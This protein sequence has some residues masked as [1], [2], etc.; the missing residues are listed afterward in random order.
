[1]GNPLP[2]PSRSRKAKTNLNLNRRCTPGSGWQAYTLA[3]NR[4]KTL[5]HALGFIA[6]FQMLL[7][8]GEIGLA[9][10]NIPV[11]SPVDAPVQVVSVPFYTR[12]SYPEALIVAITEPYYVKQGEDKEASNFNLAA[13]AKL[14]IYGTYLYQKSG[15]KAAGFYIEWNFSKVDPKKIN[16]DLIA[17]VIECINK[18]LGDEMPIYSKFIGVEKYPEI[19]KQITAVFPLI[20]PKE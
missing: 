11:H 19:E 20:P 5:I 1:M 15:A 4:M 3:N 9:T 7:E 6:I 18:T 14:S 10:A 13:E 16:K 2:A 12:G 8:A 17:G